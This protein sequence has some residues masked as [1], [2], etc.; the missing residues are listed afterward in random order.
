M[1]VKKRPT[2]FT[3]LS[4]IGMFLLFE[5]IVW[6]IFMIKQDSLM[7]NIVRMTCFLLTAFLVYSLWTVKKWA[8]IVF[9][10]LA[11]VSQIFILI[12]MNS[13]M[14][15]MTVSVFV[16]VFVMLIN[17]TGCILVGMYIC[18]KLKEWNK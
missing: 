7:N 4:Y 2:G 11:L 17:I 5:Y 9:I 13:W 1:S 18:R 14:L 8:L 15:S 16:S 6:F 12:E 10:L 3:V